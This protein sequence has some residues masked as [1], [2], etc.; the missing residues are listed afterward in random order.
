MWHPIETA[1]EGKGKDG[2]AFFLLA[3][4]DK[5]DPSTGKG[6][7]WRDRWF[8]AGCFHR[9]GSERQHEIREIEVTPHLWMP[10]PS[11]LISEE[12]P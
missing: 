9:P 12:R 1:P 7:R 3:W 4:G 6:F 10:I 11:A 5:E 8:A 2:V